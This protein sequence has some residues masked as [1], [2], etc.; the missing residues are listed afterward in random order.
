[1]ANQKPELDLDIQKR[2]MYRDLIAAFDISSTPNREFQGLHYS[3]VKI[4]GDLTR[5]SAIQK[6][7]L[8]TD[9]IAHTAAEM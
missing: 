8:L 5:I 4:S 6:A 2:L 9:R 7:F 1:M 3:Y